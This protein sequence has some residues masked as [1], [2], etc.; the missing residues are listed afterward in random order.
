MRS[1]KADCE[2]RAA[3]KEKASRRTDLAARLNERRAAEERLAAEHAARLR[4]EEQLRRVASEA[5]LTADGL[6]EVVQALRSWLVEQE[7]QAALRKKRDEDRARLEQVLEGKSMQQLEQELEKR[8]SELPELP[9]ETEQPEGGA[10]ASLARR[11]GELA[12]LESRCS[13]LEREIAR[14]DGELSNLEKELGSLAEALEAEERAAAEHRG[15]ASLDSA[16]ARTEELLT[17][18]RATAHANLAPHIDR[19]LLPWIRKITD[20]RYVDVRVDPDTL[21]IDVNDAHGA[22]RE[23]RLLSHGTAEQIFLLL[24]V[25]LSALLA[26]TGE[27]PPLILDDVLVQSDSPRTRA[28]LELLHELSAERQVIL[29]SQEEEVLDW[30]E[31]SLVPDRDVLLRLPSP[32]T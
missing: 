22:S 11:D 3:L 2:S 23:A 18:A 10:D 7:E 21:Q 31:R 19:M 9:E 13:A 28:L 25:A 26:T 15:L 29:F 12:D 30:A 6:E 17:E 16:L 5:G 8:R 24:R 4:A 14:Q 1:Y 20:G 32:A 27:T